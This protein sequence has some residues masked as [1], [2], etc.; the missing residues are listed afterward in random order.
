MSVDF[1]SRVIEIAL[2]KRSEGREPIEQVSFTV[3]EKVVLWSGDYGNGAVSE[4]F[5]ITVE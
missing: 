3:E 5:V 2:P 4:S 1:Y